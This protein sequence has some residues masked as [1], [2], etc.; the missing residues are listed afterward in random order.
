MITGRKLTREE[1]W[2]RIQKTSKDEVILAE[3]KRLGFW[4]SGSPQPGFAE[5]FVQERAQLETKL[6]NL[7][8]ELA[9]V[10][11]PAQALKLHHQE[12]KK[13][14]LEKREET[15]RKRNTE[16]FERATHWHR[17]QLESI[18]YLGDGH[19]K[20]LAQKSLDSGRL[21]A[22]SL[23]LIGNAAEL[24]AAMGIT[25][26]ELRFLA[27]QRD[28]S[29][30]SHYQRFAIPK[31]TGGERIISA[32]MPRLKRAQ[33]WL[34]ANVLEKIPVTESAQGFVKQ[35]NI[36]TNARP[37]VGKKVVVNLD[38][39]N[40]FPSIGYARVKGIF[41]QLGFSEEIATLCARLTTEAPVS[42]FELDGMRYF[43][44]T[45]AAALPQGAPTS[46]ALSNLLC[47]RLDKRLRGAAAKLDFAYTRYADDLTFSSPTADNLAIKKL[48]WRVR[49]IVEA[50][51]L[52][53]H[54]R[55]TAVMRKHQRQEVTGVV[56]NQK[57]SVCREELRK[58]RALLF[59]IEKD[60]PEGKRWREGSLFNS[61]EGYAN[62]VAMVNPEKGKPL[63]ERVKSLRRKY[64]SPARPFAKSALGAERF[65]ASA[66]AGQAPRENWWQ[67]QLRPVPVLELTQIQRDEI[68]QREK[69]A[70]LAAEAAANPAAA[71]AAAAS[72]ART[73][74]GRSGG[75]AGAHPYIPPPRPQRPPE[76]GELPRWVW[77]LI[78]LVIW[79]VARQLIR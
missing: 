64:Q 69:A 14:A 38:L 3:M 29:T 20:A 75:G 21:S 15:R 67:P 59:Q 17:R 22:Q 62:F 30:V 40:F 49:K 60:G 77:W 9:K 19:F 51:G 63:Q 12:R 50:E 72:T 33:Y 79:I 74:P 56:V 23:P 5:S 54:P 76:S 11:D 4:P 70:K 73:S 32:P 31:K 34:L 28:V 37:H 18:S 2:E 61:V 8:A 10:Q 48:L 46:P 53:V 35:R 39:E 26:A 24:A 6:R 41:R 36:L 27:Y 16:R 43:V 25:L 1:I 13:A 71:A 45:G 68:K 57:P 55:K 66:A 58:F 44:K 52:K 47:R 65:R 78:V 7:T 42:A